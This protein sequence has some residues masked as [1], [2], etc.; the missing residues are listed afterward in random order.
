VKTADEG[1]KARR[2]LFTPDEQERRA[3]RDE[4]RR[5]KPQGRKKHGRG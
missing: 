2:P 4:V 5:Q 3:D 1:S